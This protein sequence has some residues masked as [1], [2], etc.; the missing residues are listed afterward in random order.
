MNNDL[1]EDFKRKFKSK[2]WRVNNLYK[3]VD[4]KGRKIT[5]KFNPTQQRL[6]NEC[7]NDEGELVEKPT[8][9]KAR[10]VGITTFW[11]IVYLDD[12]LWTP[13][14]RAFIQ[15]HDDDSIKII[16]ETIKNAYENMPDFIKPP[17][18]RGGGSAYKYKFPSTGSSIEVGLKFR[19]GTLHR[20]HFSEKAFMQPKRAMATIGALPPGSN[21]SE[22]TTPDGM[23]HYYDSWIDEVKVKKKRIFIAWF[24][25]AEYALHDIDTG[26]SDEEEIKYLAHVKDQCGVE[27]TKAQIEFRRDKIS[28][29]GSVD[30]FN[31]EYASDPITCFVGSG[32]PYFNMKNIAKAK[33]EIKPVIRVAENGLNIV[34]EFVPGKKYLM[35]ADCAEGLPHG[36]ASTVSIVRRDTREE[37]AFMEDQWDPKVHAEILMECGLMYSTSKYNVPQLAPERNNT[38]HAVI[39]ALREIQKYYNLYYEAKGKCGWGTD[40]ISRAQGLLNLSEGI[41]EGSYWP[42]NP[43]FYKEAFTFVKNKNGKPEAESG[44]HDDVILTQHIVAGILGD[45]NPT[46]SDKFPVTGIGKISLENMLIK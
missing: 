40:K 26:P 1:P 25:V 35:V 29:F 31:Q 23:N 14:I 38:G 5:F 37:V 15:S 46:V 19:S 44:R 3:I 36:D 9:L 12:V 18:D 30:Q 17:L 34:E 2:Y 4:K 24:D 16:F 43:Q 22:E 8:I 13:N 10:Q 21:Y 33:A 39:L 7:F 41:N 27:L 42:N 6:W 20:L 11:G 28:E 32:T 45:A